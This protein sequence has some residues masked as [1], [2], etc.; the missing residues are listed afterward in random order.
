MSNEQISIGRFSQITRLTQKA[1]RLYDQREILIPAIKDTLTGYRY[2]SVLQIERALKIKFLINLGFSLDEVTSL[3][4]AADTD[5]KD[6]IRISFSNKLLEV[7]GEI[8]QLKEIEEILL[9]KTSSMEAL[10]VS[11]TEPTIKKVTKMRVISKR[12]IGPYNRTINKLISEIMGL[13][14]KTNNSG[15][16]VM[17]IGPPIYI[18]HDKGY[19]D[20]NADI[21]IAI[22]IT[23]RISIDQDFE[24]KYL[25]AGK[26][27]STIHTGP[28]RNI[29]E[30]YTKIFEYAMKN[31]LQ[32]AGLTRE[33]YITDP[34]GKPENELIT[35]VQLPVE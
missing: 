3:L 14:F 32:I 12:A 27:V 11:T 5:N 15:E 19:N 33:I 35:E 18:C 6:L 4:N 31:G 7:Q 10:F 22:P 30:A 1:L 34:K 28:Y 29:G 20:V 16:R 8:Q 24:V 26:V 21:E 2:Y 25:P 13:I 17:I 9:E 23:G